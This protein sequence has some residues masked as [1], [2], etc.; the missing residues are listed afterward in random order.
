NVSA[1]TFL[2]LN[3]TNQNVNFSNLRIGLS[4]QGNISNFIGPGDWFY[5]S[6]IYHHKN[7]SSIILQIQKPNKTIGITNLSHLTAITIRNTPGQSGYGYLNVSSIKFARDLVQ[8]NAIIKTITPGANISYPIA[9]N[10]RISIEYNYSAA[11]NPSG[12]WVSE[13]FNKPLNVSAS[14]FLVLNVTNQNVNFSNLRIGLS[15]QG[16]ISNFI[17]PGD[18]FNVNEQNGIFTAFINRNNNNW[19]IIIQTHH[20]TCNNGPT[21]LSH[22]TAIT[23]RN[24]PGQSGYG[25]LNVSS[26]KFANSNV[27]IESKI[28]SN[29]LTTLG[30]KYALVDSSIQDTP[31]PYRIGNYY[32]KLLCNS[33]YF[34]EIYKNKSLTLFK[35]LNYMGLFSTANRLFFSESNALLGSVYYNS[36]FNDS[37]VF[38]N[39]LALV[40]D[41]KRITSKAQISYIEINPVKYNLNIRSNGS[42]VL[43]F[44][45]TFNNNFV[46]ETS[47][48]TVLKYHFLANGYANGWIVPQNV[49]SL[50]IYYKGSKAYML[51]ELAFVIFPFLA[52]ALFLILEVRKLS[53]T[54]CRKKQILV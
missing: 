10:P 30:F 26:I 46:A 11:T 47:N 13:I 39:D 16:N 12:V 6:F 15:F 1:S 24:T 32:N 8:D 17:G 25:Y 4:F 14:T 20:Y 7:S 50:T 43:V 41:A 49:K 18:W 5:N 22:L 28:F 27:T 42:F 38:T 21:N 33:P 31:Y 37:T 9:G 53:V 40:S 23:I 54:K 19:S 44:K 48:G 36:S 2:V 51:T 45:E 52:L 29:D 34:K 35:N 3:V